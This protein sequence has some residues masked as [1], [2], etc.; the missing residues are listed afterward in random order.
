[1]VQPPAEAYRSR[2]ANDAGDGIARVVITNPFRRP[3]GLIGPGLRILN[4]ATLSAE[5]HQ[6][7]QALF[8]MISSATLRGTGS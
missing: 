3:A 5:P 7:S 6:V 2:N 4:A 1:V 8:A